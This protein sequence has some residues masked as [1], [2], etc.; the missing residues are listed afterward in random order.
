MEFGV[1]SRTSN[2]TLKEALKCFMWEVCHC[3]AVAQLKVHSI[4]NAE[5][6]KKGACVF[7]NRNVWAPNLALW[8]ATAP[9]LAQ[10]GTFLIAALMCE[11]IWSWQAVTQVC[12]SELEGS[13]TSKQREW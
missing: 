2:I 8:E 3:T 4:C 1:K 13:Y 6:K 11:R 10:R 5:G 12:T 7:K 9:L